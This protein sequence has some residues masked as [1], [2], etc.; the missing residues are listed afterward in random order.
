MT[1]KSGN[2]AHSAEVLRPGDPD[3]EKLKR[4]IAEFDCVEPLVWNRRSGNLVGGHQRLKVLIARG[5]S[6]V[7]CV[8]VDMPPEREKA[9]N[10]AL[11]KISGDWDKDKLARLLDELV[12][13]PE[14]DVG[15]TGFDVPEVSQL[16]DRLLP[17]DAEDD[18]FD[19][20]KELEA[21]Q[22]PQTTPG[23]LIELGPHR[24]LCGDC[25]EPQDVARLMG[26]ATAQ[27]IFTDPPYGVRLMY[28]VA[29]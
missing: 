2:L 27:L 11:N 14:F 26:E 18:G 5:D 23:E 16:L 21:I 29:A 7:P 10:L 28:R 22:E 20:E 17:E 1:H 19:V 3:Y 25:T 4:S 8:V 12:Q 6:E 13:V 15:L 24:V 9:L